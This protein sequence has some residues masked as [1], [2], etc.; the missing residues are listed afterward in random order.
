MTL[1]HTVVWLDHQDATII[2]FSFDAQH[3]L[4]VHH[5]SE[6][7]KLHHKVNTIGSGRTPE[8]PEYFRQIV[9][10]IKDAHD[11]LIAGPSTAKLAFH[12]HLI[13]HEA[14]LARRVVA[15]ETI[16]H[17]SEGQLLDYA[18]KYFKAVDNMVGHNG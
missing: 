8:D 2:D 5:D 16:N 4:H 9:V 18:R 12:R 14:A 6:D 13:K 10:V 7:R 15:V 1:R 3:V 11:I 17:P